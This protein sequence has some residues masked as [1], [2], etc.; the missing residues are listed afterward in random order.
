MMVLEPKETLELLI[1]MLGY[2]RE[3]NGGN[4]VFVG[5]YFTV[6]RRGVLE[7]DKMLEE[8]RRVAN[9]T[10]EQKM[11]AERAKQNALEAKRKMAADKAHKEMVLR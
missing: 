11:Q 1:E 3:D 6:L 8:R 5:D 10:E 7:I 9:L 2:F 4:F